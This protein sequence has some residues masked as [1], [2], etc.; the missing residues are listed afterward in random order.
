MKNM[1]TPNNVAPI[2]MSI[3]ADINNYNNINYL[4]IFNF[5]YQDLF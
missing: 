2:A 4:N 3:L 1:E 5:N